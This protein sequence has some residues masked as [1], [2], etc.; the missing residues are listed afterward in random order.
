VYCYAR[1]THEYLGFSAGLEFETRVM[2]KESA[3]A[4]LREALASPKWSPQ[5]IGL[6]G[7]TD[8]YQPVERK[9]K[10]TR[11]CLEVLRDFRNPVIVITKNR[12]VARDVD[13]LGEL[14]LHNAAS[15]YLSIST[16]DLGLNRI[17]EPRTSSPAQRLQAVR[18]LSDAGVP[19]GVLVA[20]VIP[21]LTDHEIAPV[22][23]AAGKAGARFAGTI[24][25]RLPLAVAP[26]FEQWLDQHFPDRKDKVLNRI[27]SMR[28]GKLYDSSFEARMSGKG[29]FAEQ[30]QSMFSIACRKAGFSEE[31]GSRNSTA[32]FRRPPEPFQQMPLFD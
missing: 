12:L 27:R 15:V 4:L 28:G 6:S 21:G 31:D 26:L 14:A 29:P 20:P 16:L 24:V 22:V 2:V 30:I 17:L 18:E 5:P 10:L 8:P 13:L 11:R 23:E 19:V 7:V 32:A 1:P 9:L 25:L 3:P